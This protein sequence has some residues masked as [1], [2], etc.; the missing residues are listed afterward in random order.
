MFQS[1]PPHGGR[2][3]IPRLRGFDAVSIHAPAR[4]A[5]RVEHFTLFVYWFQSTPPHGGRLF[6]C[7]V[8]FYVGPF[9]S[10]PPHGGRRE[11]ICSSVQFGG[12][13]IHAPARGATGYVQEQSTRA[14]SFNPRP[15][16]GGDTRCV[17]PWGDIAGFQSTPPQRGATLCITRQN[18][19]AL[20][21]ST[22]P[23]GGRLR[24]DAASGRWSCF[25]PRPRTGGDLIY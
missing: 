13:S 18:E 8:W 7:V 25:N 3:K 10:T 12:V 23:H 4:G 6:H 14:G 11:I 22:P 9:Q 16:T 2:L 19:L 17:H 21:Q 1:T 15:R 5:T 24:S 20:F